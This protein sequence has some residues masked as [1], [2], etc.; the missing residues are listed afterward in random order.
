MIYIVIP[1]YNGAEHLK[2]CFP[3]I[4]GQ[5]SRDYR[6][7][8]I[9][10]G[11]DDDS[12]SFTKSNYPAYVIIGLGKNYGFAKA[13]NEG[14][15]YSI[16][17]S[18]CEYI[19]LLNND[20]ELHP[21]FIRTGVE[22]FK[23]NNEISF[24][25][26]KM[27]NYY[28]RKIIDD[29]GDF[30]K[31]NGGSPLARGHDEIDTGQYDSAEFIFGACAGAAF[32]K[33]GLFEKVGLFDDSFFAYY[34]DIDFSFRAQLMGYKCWYLPQAVC[35]HKRGGTIGIATEG[36]QTEL[37]ERNLILL[38]IKNYPLGLLLFNQPFFLAARLK[39]YYLFIRRHSLTVFLRAV[40]GYLRGLFLILF[41]LRKRFSIQRNTVVSS[42]YIKG[43]FVK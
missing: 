40:K 18:D 6:V 27:L 36:F 33:R 8:L 10:N 43:L 4:E 2:T 21:D 17:N 14:I 28:D 39:R 38:R 11:S 34:E 3:S 7:V 20:I 22:T 5:S 37:C 24:I 1:N 41:Q 32:Y 12:V 9:D 19:L 13:I 31:G 29:C 25:A 35:Y 15:I 23:T 30:I 16:K 26:V 42:R